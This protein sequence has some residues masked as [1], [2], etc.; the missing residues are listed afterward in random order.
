M[1]S[2]RGGVHVGA[3]YTEKSLQAERK[4]ARV[5]L[6]VTG[7][8]ASRARLGSARLRSWAEVGSLFNARHLLSGTQSF[9][10]EV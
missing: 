7:M 6:A 10:L 8:E 5:H 4:I 2:G 9:S 3:I 1:G